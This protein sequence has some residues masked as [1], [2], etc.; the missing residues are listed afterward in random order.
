MPSTLLAPAQLQSH[1]D[2]GNDNAVDDGYDFPHRCR[3][4][5]LKRREGIGVHGLCQDLSWSK[6][7]PEGLRLSFMRV[8]AFEKIF[9]LVEMVTILS[10]LP[11]QRMVE[12]RLA[13]SPSLL[14]RY[15]FLL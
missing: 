2:T 6:Q 1:D 3:A 10:M 4:L 5:S 8:L 14:T 7:R 12:I 11:Q 9:S 15:V 13:S